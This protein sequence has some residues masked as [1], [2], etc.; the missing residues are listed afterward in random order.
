MSLRLCPRC[1]HRMVPGANFCPRCGKALAPAPPPPLKSARRSPAQPGP[2]ALPAGGF[3][4]VVGSV[5]GG[6]L[7]VVLLL[8][9]N[10]TDAFLLVV[11]LFLIGVSLAA[12]A[13]AVSCMGGAAPG[14]AGAPARRPAAQR[15]G[16]REQP[17]EP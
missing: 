17:L 2:D 3:L 9:A 15:S 4:A 11:G 10:R 12:L 6:G 8:A 1:P 5:I 13:T 7:G 16:L 14:Q